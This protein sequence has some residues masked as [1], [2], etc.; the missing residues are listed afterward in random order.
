M[1]RLAEL[2]VR[3]V[4]VEVLRGPQGTLYGSGAVAGT[5]R[6]IHNQ[7]DPSKFTAEISADASG[8]SHAANG[9][10]TVDGLVNIPISDAVVFDARAQPILTDPANPLTSNFQTESLRGIDSA[11]STY[12]RA[13]LLWHVAPWFDA[14][15][16]YQR[17]DDRSNGFSR[18][19]QGQSYVD[20]VFIPLAPDHRTVDL[21]ALTLTA[22]VGFATVTSS[23]SFTKNHDT[24]SYDESPFLLNYDSL[25]PLYYGSYPRPTAFF[26]T[27]T[28]TSLV[29]RAAARAPVRKQPDQPGRHFGRGA[30]AQECQCLPRLPRGV[31]DTAANR[32]AVIAIYLR[33]R[34]SRRRGSALSRW[35]G[36]IDRLTRRQ[37][38]VVNVAI[39]PLLPGGALAPQTAACLP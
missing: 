30:G 6:I 2:P 28:D 15:L 24:S 31:C 32:G 7:P 3:T 36:W 23:T 1:R 5:I 33:L 11:R 25:S 35:I 37:G 10:Y 17:Q 21:E 18:E 9:S 20:N 19:T 16:A 27:Y 12:A 13:S 8:T 34:A 26:T 14:T 38:G 39:R 22:D 4:R 29:R